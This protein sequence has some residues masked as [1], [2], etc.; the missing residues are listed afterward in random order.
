M[1]HFIDIDD[2]AT[3]NENQDDE[4][5]YSL[6]DDDAELENNVIDTNRNASSRRRIEEYREL[7]RLRD[8]LDDPFFDYD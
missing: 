7:Q 1:A 5:I 8:E 2:S 4:V 6:L 3:D